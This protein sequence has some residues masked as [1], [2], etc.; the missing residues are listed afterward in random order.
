MRLGPVSIDMEHLRSAV[1]EGLGSDTHVTGMQVFILRSHGKDQMTIRV[2]SEVANEAKSK[3]K[4]LEQLEKMRPMLR[5]HIR[6]GLIA[7]CDVEFVSA[8]ELE[9]NWRTGKIVNIVDLRPTE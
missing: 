2:A 1:A 7:P 3:H 8:Q 5:E 4:I 9:V 6:K